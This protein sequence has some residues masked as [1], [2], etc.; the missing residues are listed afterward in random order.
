MGR[1]YTENRISTEVKIWKKKQMKRW[2]NLNNGRNSKLCNK[3]LI[4][5]LIMRFQDHQFLSLMH[6]QRSIQTNRCEI[7]EAMVQ[8]FSIHFQC[9]CDCRDLHHESTPQ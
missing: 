1:K 7:E 4:F 8:V 9:N 5:F 2:E 6:Y 3:G